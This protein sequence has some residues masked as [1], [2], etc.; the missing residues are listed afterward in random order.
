[1]KYNKDKVDYMGNKEDFRMKID[2]N[3]FG[4]GDWNE[5][6]SAFCDSKENSDGSDVRV[7]YVAKFGVFSNPKAWGRLLASL[8]KTIATGEVKTR[9]GKESDIEVLEAKIVEGFNDVLIGTDSIK[10]QRMG[11][12]ED[13]LPISP[14]K[15]NKNWDP[16]TSDWT[17]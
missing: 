3:F 4:P 15:P 6:L 11:I 17:K 10:L 9:G 5:I 12:F 2:E 1:M 7:S 8:V 13:D 14:E 16:G